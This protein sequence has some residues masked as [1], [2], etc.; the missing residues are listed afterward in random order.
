M[1]SVPT[2][3]LLISMFLDGFVAGKGCTLVDAPD[4]RW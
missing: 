4:R 3:R 2:L 1:P